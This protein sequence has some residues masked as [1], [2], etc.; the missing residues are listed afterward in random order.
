MMTVEL[1]SEKISPKS[2]N[3]LSCNAV[4]LSRMSGNSIRSPARRDD[5]G[6]E[7]TVGYRGPYS[8]GRA[9]RAGED[10]RSRKEHVWGRR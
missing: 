7:V 8:G 9:R 3:S 10:G 4:G 2:W 5:R 6:R 1:F